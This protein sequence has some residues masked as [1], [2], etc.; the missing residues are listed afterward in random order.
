MCIKLNT[1]YEF[2]HSEKDT[3][4]KSNIKELPL[5]PRRLLLDIQFFPGTGSP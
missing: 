5:V 3:L 4:Q 1:Y 2:H